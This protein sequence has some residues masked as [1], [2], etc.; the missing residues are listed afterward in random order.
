MSGA[1]A[2]NRGATSDAGRRAGFARE[3]RPAILGGLIVITLALVGFAAW[4][5]TAPLASAIVAPGIVMVDG[6]RKQVQHLEGGIVKEILVKDG[7]RVER[8]QVLLRLDESRARSTL[9]VLQTAL[10]TARILEARL[11]AER[12][13]SDTLVFPTDLRARRP[14]RT[15]AEMMRAQELLFAA[16]RTSFLGQQDILRQ[17][18]AGHEQEIAGLAAQQESLEQQ[19]RFVEEELA[20]LRELLAKGIALQRC[21]RSSAKRRGSADRVA[22]GFR[23]LPGRRCRS[24]EQSSKFSSWSGHSMKTSPR[25]SGTSR[26]R[27]PI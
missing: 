18:I 26:L 7:A 10:D 6:N 14:D 24:A 17:R 27:S 5:A 22:S 12:D 16:R 23:T 20:G 19:I 8:E 25:R 4:A 9:G 3:A 2:P 1:A 11:K 15:I 13:G 21:W